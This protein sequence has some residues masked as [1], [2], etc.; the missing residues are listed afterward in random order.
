MAA[1]GERDIQP[2]Q[3]ACYNAFNILSRYYTCQFF[4]R[5]FY[6]VHVDS[7]PRMDYYSVQGP[8]CCELPST[9][10]NDFD[11]SLPSL[12]YLIVET[13]SLLPSLEKYQSYDA[14]KLEQA[15]ACYVL[16]NSVHPVINIVIC[17]RKLAVDAVYYRQDN[18]QGLKLRKKHR[19]SWFCLVF[20]PD[21][22]ENDGKLQTMEKTVEDPQVLS[23]LRNL[24]PC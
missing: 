7:V 12:F 5:T 2:K 6:T 11:L 8:Q 19:L 23:I 22:L 17:F 9:N 10:T 21:V 4:F 13:P 16:I 3:P 18:F 20:F 15:F 14:F 1:A 24:A